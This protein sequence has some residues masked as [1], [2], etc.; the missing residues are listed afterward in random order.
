MYIYHPQNDKYKTWQLMGETFQRKWDRMWKRGRGGFFFQGT[1][2][3]T[4]GE[5][6]NFWNT[7][8][9]KGVA[10]RTI[11]KVCEKDTGY[12]IE[13]NPCDSWLR[14]GIL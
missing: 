8:V 6:I 13:G 10:L 14:Q 12:D 7:T 3:E 5:Y 1:R 9:A 2:T 11:Y 4:L